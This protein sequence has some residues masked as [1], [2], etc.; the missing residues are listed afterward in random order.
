MHWT[1]RPLKHSESFSLWSIVEGQGDRSWILTAI[2]E[3]TFVCVVS[4][5]AI[6]HRMRSHTDRCISCFNRRVRGSYYARKEREQAE[7]LHGRVSWCR[8][9]LTPDENWS[10]CQIERVSE[11]HG[12]NNPILYMPY[13]HRA[14]PSW[15]VLQHSTVLAVG[16]NLYRIITKLMH[17]PDRSSSRA[18][19]Y[20]HGKSDPSFHVTM[21]LWDKT[22]YQEFVDPRISPA[23]F[24]LLFH[25]FYDTFKLLIGARLL[26]ILI[27][28]PKTDAQ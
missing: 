20:S 28:K 15:N 12:V 16:L 24:S 11:D 17:K 5:P 25:D 14:E 7:K 2:D 21:G 19:V 18:L 1:Y 22:L 8:R 23:L 6:I 27:S 26:K 13:F 3:S 9:I 4:H 10:E